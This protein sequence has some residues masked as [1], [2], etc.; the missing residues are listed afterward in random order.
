MHRK[1]LSMFFLSLFFA[2]ACNNGGK[3]A[4]DDKLA[5]GKIVVAATEE[6]FDLV[7]EIAASYENKNS[8]I[9]IEVRQ[10]S[11]SDMKS[12]IDKGEAQVVV[13]GGSENPLAEYN[14]SVIAV[15]LLVLAVNFYNPALQTLTMRGIDPKQLQEIFI[16]GS[17][18]SWKQVSK[19]SE[20]VLIKAFAAPDNTNFNS[21]MKLFLNSEIN[22]DIERV[23]SEKEIHSSILSDKGTISFISS[24]DAYSK[25]SG[26]RNGDIYIIP[27]DL[28]ENG[29]AD[30]NELIF[31]D[32]K[33]LE[34]S[35]AKGLYDDKLV[36][37]HFFIFSE[38]AT[39]KDIV[40]DFLNFAKN[41]SKEKR[42]AGY[43][44]PIKK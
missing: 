12:L 36:R 37:K 38:K 4:S 33:M 16:S 34:K 2:F 39:R 22:K 28:N 41:V 26:R 23:L 9:T 35:Y 42:D 25:T 3:N 11:A 17:L 19:N 21:F 8:Q 32:I 29:I 7:R 27:I 1:L 6:S 20:N 5:A 40:D 15:D 44:E 24:R 43:F 13:G 18:K 30:D 31:D 10:C 14:S